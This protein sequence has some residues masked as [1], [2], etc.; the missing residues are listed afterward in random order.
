MNNVV[1]TKVKFYRNLKDYKF[2]NKLTAE[3]KSEIISKLKE[4]L[5]GYS[6]V[7]IA[8]ADEN[9]I[10]YLKNYKMINLKS[11][12]LF[13]SQKENVCIDLFAGEHL[14]II[15]VANGFDK[16]AF[17]K[18]KKI[19]EI[20]NSKISMAFNDEFGYLMSD[21]TH[22]GAGLKMEA[23]IC[24]NALNSIQKTEQVKQNVRKLG[25]ILKETERTNVYKLSTMCNLG[26]SE[27]EIV[28][29]FEKILNK[30]QDLEIESLK[31]LDTNNHEEF[32]D[33]V[34]RSFAI[35]NYANLMSHEELHNHII[36]LRSGLNLNI[37]NIQLKTINQLQNL[38]NT[39]KDIVSQSEL[40][41][42]A[43]DVK[44]ILKGEQNV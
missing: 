13:F 21:I 41:Q 16:S 28:D 2:S 3:K 18:A 36:N 32:V 12:I 8:N 42:L 23:E 26:F 14:K 33:K 44:N 39:Q 17:E 34:N 15:A 38:T 30:L 6:F 5:K 29:E 4:I 40:K 37:S 27:K 19:I 31:M 7:E 10:K 35:L 22:I 20:L 43:Q 25:Y 1:F 9:L 24:L 11:K